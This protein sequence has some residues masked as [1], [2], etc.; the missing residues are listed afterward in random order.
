MAS[1]FVPPVTQ[2]VNDDA[3]DIASGWLLNFYLTGTLT[4]K[5]TFSDNALTTANAN[6]VVADSSGRFG[7][8]FLEAGTYKVVLTDADAVEKWTADPVQGGL[9]SSGAVDEKTA[10]YT[11][12]IDDASKII[13]VDASS[14]A[15]T[16]TLL[17]SAT[18][19]DGFEVTI[20]KTDSS[21]NAVT[22]D[23]DGSETIDGATTYLLGT[24]YESVTVR[25]DASNWLVPFSHSAAEDADFIIAAQAFGD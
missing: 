6:P 9:G 22:T 5:D 15:I 3:S 18:A 4:R 7:D 2:L 23:G 14:G 12:T 25:S 8:I 24:Q 17:A 10:N 13:A 19:G 11:V 20:K 21:A 16:I 1:R